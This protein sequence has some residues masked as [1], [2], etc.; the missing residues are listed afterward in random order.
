[1]ASNRALKKAAA[2]MADRTLK[3]AVA[4]MADRVL[5]EAV[6]RMTDSVAAM[7]KEM[8]ESRRMHEQILARLSASSERME[9]R[10][11]DLS[12]NMGGLNNRFGY[13][14]EVLVV[15]GIRPKLR[16]VGRDFEYITAN[17][18]VRGYPDGE[19]RKKDITEIDMFLCSDSEAMAVEIKT[20]LSV[21]YIKDHIEQ[22]E[23]LRKYEN[24]AGIQNKT[25][26]GAVVGAI[27]DDNARNFARDN[28][29]FV[30][31]ISED[32]YALK[33]DAPEQCRTW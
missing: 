3:E 11:D 8:A 21:A 4:R 28:G 30:M 32:E 13:L 1:M 5:E 22:L 10:V 18:I 19:G 14:V 33:M 15:P 7:S 29:L 27:I 12:A 6:A 2:R 31:E 24:E 26:Y 20:R 25:L 23:I 9:R 16:E 17:K